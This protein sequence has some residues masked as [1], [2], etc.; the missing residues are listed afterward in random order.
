MSIYLYGGGL[1]ILFLL[2]I[3]AWLINAFGYRMDIQSLITFF[4]SYTSATV[5]GAIAFVSIFSIN[6]NNDGN[7]DIAEKKSVEGNTNISA[8]KTL[9]NTVKGNT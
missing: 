9:V 3:S 1:M 6:K 5:V 8:V 4:N 2:F 7:S